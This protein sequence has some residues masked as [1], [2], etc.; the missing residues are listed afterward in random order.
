MSNKLSTEVRG[1]EASRSRDQ[2][3]ASSLAKEGVVRKIRRTHLER[4]AVVYVRQSTAKQVLQ[5]RESQELQYALAQRAQAFGWPESRVLIIDDDLGQSGRSAE[6]RVGF[7]R[8]LAEI[9]L[10]QVGLVLGIEMSRLA[11]SCK[12]WYQLLELCAI[13]D[14]LL[15][16]QDGMYDPAN[17]NDRLLLGLKGTMSEAELHIIRNRMQ[18]GARNKARRG[19]LLTR[20]PMG[21]VFGSEGEVLLDP[22]EQTR[23][24]VRLVFDKFDEIGTGRGTAQYLRRHKIRFPFV[25]YTGPN[26][27]TVEWRLPCLTTI[28]SILGHPLY[29]GAY[30]YGRRQVDPRSKIRGKPHS[31]RISHNID[32]WEVLLPDRW[33]GYITWDKYLENQSRLRQNRSLPNTQGAPRKGPTLLPGLVHCGKCGWRLRVM[34]HVGSY[35]PTYFCPRQAS[36][37]DHSVCQSVAAQSLDALVSQLVLKAVEPAALAV[38]LQATENIELERQRLQTHLCQEL[39]RAQYGTQRARRHYLAVEPENRLVGRELEKQWEQAMREQSQ[40]QEQLD[41]FQQDRP[42]QLSTVERA[43]IEALARDLPVLW[44]DE[45]VGIIDRQQV[46]RALIERVVVNVQGTTEYVDVAIHWKGGFV[47]QHEMQRPV[48]RYN[49]MRD[50]DRLKARIIELRRQGKVKREIAEQLNQEGFQ[51]PHRNHAFNEPIVSSLL[52][53]WGQ[54]DPRIDSLTYAHCL[55][56]D[57]YWLRDLSL[58]LKIPQSVLAKWCVRGW[59]HA[60]QVM[61]LRRRW[62]IWVDASEKRRL[63]KLRASRRLGP[64]RQYPV[65]LTTPGPKSKSGSK[66]SK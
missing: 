32:E 10:N 60:R 62:I 39:E 17:Y 43:T 27:G 50:Y 25:V 66:A 16:D 38:S 26:K 15:A 57:E 29:S 35:S 56:R 64:S 8:L 12:D 63:A 61:I 44:N 5:N 34:Y 37:G 24:L 42:L 23:S 3:E 22:D 41:R 54:C 65:E 20:L 55:Q 46:V 40:L 9:S 2:R 53:K 13:F 18:E 33:P 28:Y 51:T 19:E 30:S 45:R 49:L 11:R 58:E 36:D 59:V 14:S 31:G 4:L 48:G 52:T 1:T 21:F 6:N 47:S 7:Q